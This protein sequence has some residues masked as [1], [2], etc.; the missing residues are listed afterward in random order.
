M[1]FD[2]FCPLTNLKA[3]HVV[4][5]LGLAA[6]AVDRAHELALDIKEYISITNC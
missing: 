1:F 4:W 3:L 2:F 5:Q 6:E